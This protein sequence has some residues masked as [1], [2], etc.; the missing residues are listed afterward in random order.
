MEVYVCVRVC[1]SMALESSISTSP[2]FTVCASSD[3]VASS[4]CSLKGS[5]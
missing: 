5:G 1:T 2:S 3:S 4:T